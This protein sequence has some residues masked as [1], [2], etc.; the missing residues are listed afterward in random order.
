MCHYLV[1]LI[2]REDKGG[3]DGKSVSGSAVRRRITYATPKCHLNIFIH[4]V[5]R[6]DG[7]MQQNCNIYCRIHSSFVLQNSPAH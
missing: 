5:L 1:S 4:G 3:S 7:F 2:I 6:P